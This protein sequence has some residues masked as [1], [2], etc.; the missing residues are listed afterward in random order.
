[1]SQLKNLLPD[2]MPREKLLANGSK[3]LSNA[4]LLA[5]LIG[6]GSKELNAVELCRLILKDNDN[7]LDKLATL[8]LSDLTSYKGIGEAKGITILSA[9]E[10]GRRRKN[11]TQIENACIQS[12][13][14]AYEILHKYLMDLTHEEFWII[15]LNRKNQVLKLVEISK[16]GFSATVVDPKLIFKAALDNKA[17][18]LILVHN[19]PSGNTQ[20][21][22]SDLVLTKKLVSAAKVLE[23]PILDHIIY[24]NAGYYSFADNH[25]LA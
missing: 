6:S 5:I 12:S 4:E 21:S 16:G 2:D 9:L 13:S 15:C 8:T 19:H 23:I 10:I 22:D 25:K 14:D 3:S 24:T 20:P 1:M 7:N 11:V 17:S 18:S